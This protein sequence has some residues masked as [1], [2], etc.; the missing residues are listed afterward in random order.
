MVN[1]IRTGPC[2][3]RK[4]YHLETRD[5]MT[6]NI[7]GYCVEVLHRSHGWWVAT[8]REYD[9]ERHQMRVRYCFERPSAKR[10][11]DAIY[12]WIDAHP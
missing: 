3:I 10:L 5:N 11:L 2:G 4:V 6:I 12:D 7:N 9:T 8:I 1:N